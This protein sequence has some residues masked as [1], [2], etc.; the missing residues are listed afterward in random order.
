MSAAATTGPATP[1][2]RRGWRATGV[3]GGA[4]E[5][6]AAADGSNHDSGVGWLGVCHVTR[7]RS[8]CSGAG[9]KAAAGW[10]GDVGSMNGD[11]DGVGS[12][13]SA[14]LAAGCRA[15]HW[16]RDDRGCRDDRR[17]GARR[18]IAAGPE[19]VVIRAGLAGVGGWSSVVR[20][21]GSYGSVGRSLMG[22]VGLRAAEDRQVNASVAVRDLVRRRRMVKNPLPPAGSGRRRA[23]RARSRASAAG[24]R[25]PPVDPSAG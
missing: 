18:S 10:A 15:G 11:A 2:D 6:A 22:Q 12:T 5:A 8:K 14:G 23:R 16:C 24:P 7:S 3:A 21:D 4:I 25:R 17:A 20:A 1:P 13:A 9:E 19:V